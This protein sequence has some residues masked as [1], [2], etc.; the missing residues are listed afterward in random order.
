MLRRSTPCPEVKLTSKATIAPTFATSPSYLLPRS[1]SVP[2]IGVTV[3]A[4]NSL[5]GAFCQQCSSSTSFPG[6]YSIDVGSNEYG[7]DFTSAY[8][9]IRRL[10]ALLHCMLQE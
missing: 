6:A 7:G 2:N 9:H 10:D 8:Y 1:S 5:H 4:M 3:Y